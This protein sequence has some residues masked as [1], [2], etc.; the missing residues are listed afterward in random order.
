M[1]CFVAGYDESNALVIIPESRKVKSA[2]RAE[3]EGFEPKRKKLSARKV[4]ALKKIVAAKY[5]IMIH[6]GCYIDSALPA[7]VLFP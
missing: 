2:D 5:G 6:T 7:L 3:E 1:L 4:K